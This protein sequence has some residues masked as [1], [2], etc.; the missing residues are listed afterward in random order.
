MSLI[1]EGHGFSVAHG[2][3]SITQSP[4]TVEIPGFSREEL[5]R[6]TQANTAVTTGDLATLKAYENFTHEF[7]YDPS[8][9][10]AWEG[11]STNREH[12][13]TFP[14]GGT[15]TGWAK[16]MSVSSPSQNTAERPTYEVTFKLTN[17]NDSDVETAPVY[18]TGS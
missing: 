11:D 10:A 18:A 1:V 14:S 13:I 15:W 4:T 7:P 5:E 12:V 9:F 3:L 8:D 17:L 2:T 6:T 16:V